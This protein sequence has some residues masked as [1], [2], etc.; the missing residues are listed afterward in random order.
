MAAK[1]GWSAIPAR[2]SN[3][4]ELGMRRR[5]LIS[6]VVVNMLSGPLSLVASVALRPKASTPVIQSSD[7]QAALASIAAQDFIAGRGTLVDYATGEAS[8]TAA[9]EPSLR[10]AGAPANTSGLGATSFAYAGATTLT[11]DLRKYE[12]H[13]FWVGTATKILRVGV[14]TTLDNAGNPVLAAQPSLLPQFVSPAAP[15]APIDFANDP[16]VLSS[17]PS[18]FEGQLSRW[19]TAFAADDRATLSDLVNNPGTYVGLGGFTVASK[20]TIITVVTDGRNDWLNIRVRLD[21]TQVGNP[22]YRVISDYDLLVKPEGDLPKI[23][24]WGAAGSTGAPLA[25]YSNAVDPNLFPTPTASATP[26][27]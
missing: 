27:K 24:A 5:L 7:P 16:G 18:G 17:V 3:S 9:L 12:V 22:G 13:T 19:A 6:L 20:P 25:A 1:S 26:K 15:V 4:M 11:V 14:T 10:I 8:T 23:I 2:R 21:L